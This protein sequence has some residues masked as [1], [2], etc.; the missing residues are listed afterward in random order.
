MRRA[1]ADNVDQMIRAIGRSFPEQ[2]RVS[3]PAGGFV[4]WLEF[5]R[6]LDSRQLLDIA[7]GKG[8]C[9]APGDVFS[10]SGRYANCLRLSCGHGWNPRV[11]NGV[12][13]L[14]RIVTT[15]LAGR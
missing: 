10:A 5:P 7:L 3:R 8:I 2:V 1:F 14:G 13:T 4:L 12:K 11:E 9:F 6:Q 15:A